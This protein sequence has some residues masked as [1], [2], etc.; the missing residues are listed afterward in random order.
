MYI[1]QIIYILI[2]FKSIRIGD[3]VDSIHLRTGLPV[4]PVV[5][6]KYP[7]TISKCQNIG[8]RLYANLLENCMDEEK[9]EEILNNIKDKHIANEVLSISQGMELVTVVLFPPDDRK[10]EILLEAIDYYCNS[11]IEHPR[12]R[13]VLYTVFYS[14]IDAYV[15]DEDEF[16]RLINMIND[17][18]TPEERQESRLLTHMRESLAN[19][20][21]KIET[22]TTENKTLTTEKETLANEN[23]TLANENETLTTEKE[24]LANENETFSRGIQDVL[25]NNSD[26]LPDNVKS[27]LQKL[28]FKKSINH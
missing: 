26:D 8:G 20:T 5:V 18:A 16:K 28:L 24:T 9:I 17:K 23:E 3:Y 25:D 6:S 12:L 13:F 2:K 4:Y 10:T 27:S 21:S 15:D 14:M 7:I 19:L 1:L 22:L 11:E